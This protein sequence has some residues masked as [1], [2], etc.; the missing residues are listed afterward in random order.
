LKSERP[1]RARTFANITRT[2]GAIHHVV[3]G[4][5]LD[6]AINRP[7]SLFTIYLPY[8]ESHHMLNIAYKLN[9]SKIS[10]G[11]FRKVSLR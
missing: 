3:K 6:A 9:Q 1:R 7:L 4:L 10:F 5:G 8:T 2:I 11:E